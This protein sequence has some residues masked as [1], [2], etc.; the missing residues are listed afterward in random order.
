[1][2]KY[3]SLYTKLERKTVEHEPK[4]SA[5]V[6]AR[7][8]GITE[9]SPI[10]LA[11]LF[12]RIQDEKDRLKAEYEAR[13][14]E[15]NVELAALDQVMQAA[16]EDAGIKDV[17]LSDGRRVA[18]DPGISVRTTNKDAVMNWFRNEGLE[19]HF[20]V[21]SATLAT[22]VKERALEGLPTPDGIEITTFNKLSLKKS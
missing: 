20:S 13:E 8:E 21:H 22:L 19:G 18:L 15:L 5:L 10:A 11:L 3:D 14:A 12:Q 9:R 6:K 16:F 17:G 2:G 7:V 4:F 1:V